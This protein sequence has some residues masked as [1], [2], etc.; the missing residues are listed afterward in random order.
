MSL[1]ERFST[2]YIFGYLSMEYFKSMRNTIWSMPKT[3]ER[4]NSFLESRHLLLLET[5]IGTIIEYIVSHL[6]T[7]I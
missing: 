6:A 1:S 2:L 4:T 7:Q 5:Q 3:E